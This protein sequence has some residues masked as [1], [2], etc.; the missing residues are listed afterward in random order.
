MSIKELLAGIDCS[1][2]RHHSCPI[3]FVA[4]EKEAIRHLTELTKDY[5]RI[6]LVADENTYAAAGKQTMDALAEKKVK[7]VI[8]SGKTV[9]I[10][11]E[12]AID[13][14]NSQLPGAEIIVGI[15]SGVIQDLCKYVSHFSGIP[16][17]I[18]ATAPSMDGYAST[19]AAMILGGMKETVAAGLPKAI[20]ADTE[21]LKDAPMDM[22]QAGYGDIVGKYSALN[23]WRLS[24]IVNGEYF[25]QEIYDLTF[26]MVE[27]TLA[28]A[29]GLVNCDPESVGVLMEA[30]VVVGIAMSFAGSSRP[31]SGSEHHLSHFF[32][33]TGIVHGKEYFPHGI[34]VA[35]STVITA[36]LRQE[37]LTRP[38]PAKQYRPEKDTYK[39][40]MTRI[41]GSVAEGCMALQEKVGLYEKNML[42]VYLEKEQQIR[43]ILSQMPKGEEIEAML[44]AVGLHFEEFYKLYGEEKIRDAIQYARE[45]K[46]RYTVLW[47]YHDMFGGSYGEN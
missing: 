4:V 38:W 3:E 34:D 41:Y 1:C 14:V 13:W 15:G 46:D 16:Y 7:Q 22:I 44:L 2:G 33:I 45:L 29:E 39:G 19:G 17:C 9:L 11:D 6:L 32:E 12:K 36:K 18:V 28:L 35:Y 37:L 27:K 26:A 21:I 20:L 31:A 43:D 30:L 10:P 23:D 25:C 42:P 8:F 47:L 40:D 5:A 24:H